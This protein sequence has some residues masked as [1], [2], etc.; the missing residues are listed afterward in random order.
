MPLMTRC[1]STRDYLFD[2]IN[3]VE[4]EYQQVL[5]KAATGA[6][7][8]PSFIRNGA[9]GTPPWPEEYRKNKDRYYSRF[10][11]PDLSPPPRTIATDE[12]AYDVEPSY[13]TKRVHAPSTAGYHAFL[14][15]EVSEPLTPPMG[16]TT[17][18]IFT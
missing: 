10:P 5:A 17:I 16:W 1:M 14:T 9:K 12:V 2:N 3:G 11:M 8:V 18:N 15:Q 4:R 13:I 6:I 7:D